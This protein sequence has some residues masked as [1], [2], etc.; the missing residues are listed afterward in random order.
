MVVAA[1]EVCVGHTGKKLS[2]VVGE[3]ELRKVC[4]RYPA[5]PQVSIFENFSIR[6][7]AGTILAL[8]GQSGSGK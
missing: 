2:Y 8:V 7:S 3:V 6:V 4:F 5:R 1:E